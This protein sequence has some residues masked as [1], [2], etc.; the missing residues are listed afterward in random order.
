MK[1]ETKKRKK[2]EF[3]HGYIILMSVMLV[4][5]V[6]S[7]IIPAGEY[8]R[9]IDPATGMEVVDPGSFSF[10]KQEDPIGFLDFFTAINAGIVK[11][12]GIGSLIVV[13]TGAIAVLD[14]TGA[15]TTGVKKII[16]K[17]KGREFTIV[18]IFLFVFIACGVVGLAE[19]MMPF[20]PIM[21]TLMMGLGY[22]RMV[23]I[24][25][26]IAGL[27]IGWT[28]GIVNIYTTGISQE[29]IGLPIFSGLGF[30]TAATILFYVIGLV[31]LYRYC[32]KIKKDPSKSIVASEYMQQCKDTT[33]AV[34]EKVVLTMKMK[35]GLAIFGIAMVIQTYGA[36]KL[37]WSYD[38]M[39]AVLIVA[40]IV[41][42]LVCGINGNEACRIFTRGASELLS[43]VFM[44]GLAQAVTALMRQAKMLDTIVYYLSKM[45]QNKGA[46]FTLLMI[47]IAIMILNFF[48]I[49]GEGKAIVMIPILSPLAKILGIN[50]QVVVLAYQYAEGFINDLYPTYGSL[51]AMLAMGKVSFGDWWRFTYKLWFTLIVVGFLLVLLAQGINLGPF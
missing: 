36:V 39:S 26:L 51:H 12:M 30:R 25:V 15:L 3:P 44:M 34:K 2:L 43:V 47:F 11:A 48:I 28:A 16:E 21:I 9:V 20:I 42:A 38:Q 1:S 37:A 24:T 4:V 5:V 29:M 33:E 23:G 17:S 50:Q 10:V 14:S 41:I 8:A 18:A 40:A 13:M 27:E 6:L 19:N 31:F 49:S 45:L 35:L 22:D 32:K 7:W 46:I